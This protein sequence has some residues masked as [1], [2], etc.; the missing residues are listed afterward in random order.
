VILNES[1]SAHHCLAVVPAS[2]FLQVDAA[3]VLRDPAQAI[4][5]HKNNLSELSATF[6]LISVVEISG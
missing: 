3:A 4:V 1:L 6:N 2:E 5:F